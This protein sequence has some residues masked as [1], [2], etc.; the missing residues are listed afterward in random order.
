MSV[1]MTAPA[2]PVDV[3]FEILA[4][5][6]GADY[7][8]ECVSQ[9]QHALQCAMLAEQA[10]SPAALI[11]AAL[12]HDI[13]H[14]ID[15]QAHQMRDSGQD[16]R[17]EVQAERYLKQWFGPDVT[18]PVRLHVDAKRYLC[19]TDIAYWDSLSDG[20]KH[21]LEMQ[22]G[23]F[24]RAEELEF[25]DLPYARDAV[26]LR[27]WDDMAKLRDAVTP[28]LEHFRQHVAASLLE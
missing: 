16:A 7:G 15:A 18:Q 4:R 14:L 25:I 23:P 9:L 8:G 5:K 20:S 22:G 3:I 12:L 24:D 10:G 6:G 17:H 28:P 1:Q 2:D 19:A 21:S 11:T 26:M 27:R 13:G